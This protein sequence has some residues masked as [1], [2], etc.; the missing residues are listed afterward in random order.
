MADTIYQGDV[1]LEVLLDCGRD[2]S[3][4]GSPAMSVKIPSGAVRTWPATIKTLDGATRYLRYVTRAGD[5]DEVGLYRIQASL[6]V[7]DWTGR[8][9]TARFTVLARFS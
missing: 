9:K 4:A 2:I 7:G 6:S 8:G 3:G 5:L 1:G